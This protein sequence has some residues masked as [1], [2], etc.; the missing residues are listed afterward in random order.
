MHI[1]GGDFQWVKSHNT[2]SKKYYLDSIKF[3]SKKIKNPTFHIY[4]DDI[5]F[6]KKLISNLLDDYNHKYLNNY[7][8]SDLEEFSLLG[9]YKYSIIANSTFSL[10]SSFVSKNNLIT[11]A[12]KKWIGNKKL[13]RE[14]TFQRMFFL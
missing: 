14:K 8:F 12:P 2:L 10:L 9:E 4:T 3:F 11:V 7:N 6:A 13:K 5:H 1:R